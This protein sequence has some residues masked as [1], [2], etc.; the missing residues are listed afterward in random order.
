MY[1]KLQQMIKELLKKLRHSLMKDKEVWQDMY[2]VFK[3]Y[4]KELKKYSTS[5]T[6]K[7]S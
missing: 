5:S 2:S 6:K 3:S 1:E 7:T 4:T